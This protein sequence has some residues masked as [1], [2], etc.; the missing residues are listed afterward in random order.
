M[1][2]LDTAAPLTPA[3]LLIGLVGSLLLSVFIALVYFKTHRGLSYS[4]A[5]LFSLVLL[6]P[7]GSAVMLIAMG[8]LL[9]AIAILGAFS[10]IRFR[11]AIKDPKD[12]AYIMLVLSVG[13]A[14]GAQMY[15]LALAVTFLIT[16]VIYLLTV[17]NFGATRRHESLLRMTCKAEKGGFVPITSYEALLAKLTKSFTLLS[18][19]VRGDGSRMELTY[20]VR[21][22]GD[23]PAAHL[24]QVLAK[25]R[26]VEHVELFDAKH[27]VEF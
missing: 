25:E 3:S 1:P 5:F 7:L 11:T 16:A 13:M 27:E 19:Q 14:M 8:N 2:P 23:E 9:R 10:I 15:L 12:M 26:G 4:Q 20:G 21:P 17:L 22:K 18:A 6:G 24:V